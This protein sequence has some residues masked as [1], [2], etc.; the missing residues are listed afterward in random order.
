MVLRPLSDRSQFEEIDELS[1]EQDVVIFK[2]STRCVISAMAWD[3]LKRDWD[4][5]VPEV[6][7]YFLDLIQY[8]AT[9][10]AV[11]SH[12]GVDHES[13]QL[14]LVRNGAVAYQTSHNGINVKDIKE[15]VN[16]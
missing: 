10:N 14:I 5:Q 2:H 12:Y 4:E 13:P 8:R 16:A 9:S 6:P 1:N 7:V 3:R 15:I 11:A